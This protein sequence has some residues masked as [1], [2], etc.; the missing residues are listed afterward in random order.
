MNILFSRSVDF[1]IPAHHVAIYILIIILCLF[2]A[3]YRAGLLISFL[4]SFYWV[5]ILNKD[6]IKVFTGGENSIYMSLYFICGA[7]VI[8]LSAWSFYMED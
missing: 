1:A 2:F 3:K 8:G 6:K 7:L 4:F 5:F